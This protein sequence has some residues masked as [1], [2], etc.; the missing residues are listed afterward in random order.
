[1]KAVG[2]I[3]LA[4]VAVFVRP[5]MQFA[6]LA[7]VVARITQHVRES[8]LIERHLDAV[9]DD[10]VRVGVAPGHQRRPIGAARDADRKALTEGRAFLGKAVH[11]GRDDRWIAVGGDVVPAQM[12]SRDEDDV[13]NLF[14]AGRFLWWKELGLAVGRRWSESG[15]AKQ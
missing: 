8:H 4:V 1:M 12:V 7:G 15:E 14:H 3:R 6:H 11:M 9:A 5:E 13:G 10:A 2:R